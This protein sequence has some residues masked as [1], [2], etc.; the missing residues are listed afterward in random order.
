MNSPT[1]A[2]VVI[3]LHKANHPPWWGDE[4]GRSSL[5]TEAALQAVGLTKPRFLLI[6][7]RFA[8]YAHTIGIFPTAW[9]N[10]PKSDSNSFHLAQTT[11]S[12]VIFS[13]FHLLHVFGSLA[14]SAGDGHGES[15]LLWLSW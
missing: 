11:R 10:F 9:K 2:T 6:R 5:E 3:K 7:T 14:V 4:L 13:P 12:H 8:L 1:A 15:A